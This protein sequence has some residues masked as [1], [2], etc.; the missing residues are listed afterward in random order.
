MQHANVPIFRPTTPEWGFPFSTHTWR[1]KSYHTI[2]YLC[3]TVF[4][5]PP[6]RKVEEDRIF[7]YVYQCRSQHV[8]TDGNT[9]ISNTFSNALCMS[10]LQL[11]KVG[12]LCPRP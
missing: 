3:T 5:H 9:A 1:Q 10:K 6:K 2:G 7:I 8:I 11:V 12:F 4:F